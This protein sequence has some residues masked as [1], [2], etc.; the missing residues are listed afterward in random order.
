MGG[1][2]MYKLDGSTSSVCYVSGLCPAAQVATCHKNGWEWEIRPACPSTG[3]DES[4]VLSLLD[5][6]TN[7]AKMDGAT[8]LNNI[9]DSRKTTSVTSHH[10]RRHFINE[11]VVRHISRLE[12]RRGRDHGAADKVRL[13]ESRYG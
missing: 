12:D 5:H 2:H 4:N 3:L 6:V 1:E 9:H 13:T 7:F 8:Q 10:R 11:D